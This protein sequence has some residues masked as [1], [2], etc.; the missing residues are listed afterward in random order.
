AYDSLTGKS[1][2]E[3][4]RDGLAHQR[5]QGAGQARTALG[6]AIS[7]WLLEESALPKTENEQSLFDG[8]DTTI[9][10]MAKLAGSTDISSDLTRISSR[11]EAAIGKFDALKPWVVASDLAAATEY[12]RALIEKVKSSSI[13]AANKDQLLFMLGNKETELNDAMNKALGLAMEVLVD[14]ERA[15]E[16]PTPFFQSRETFNVAIPGQQFSLTMSVVNRS[17]VK[18]D[19]AE[20]L[21]FPRGGWD[22]KSKSPV[23]GLPV[24][25]S[26]L[27]AQFDLKVHDNAEY[28]RPHWSRD[29]ELRDH[30]YQINKP[31]YLHLPFPPPDVIGVFNYVFEGVRFTLT[32]PAQTVYIDRPWGEQRRLLTVAPAMNVAISPRV[33]VIPIASSQA[34]FDVNVSVSNNV[35]GNATGKVRLKLPQGWAASP[36]ESSFSF[37]HEGE[38]GNF[39]FKVSVPQ[40]A[41]GAD[42]KVHAVAEYNGKEYVEGYQVIGR[43]DNEPRH[44]YRPA[45]M[46]VRGVEV[47]AAPNL[48]V[49][50]V[51]GVGDESPKALEQ[52]GAKV[53]ALG[54]NDLAKGNLDVFDA[55]I[56]GIRATA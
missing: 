4:A 53:V 1:Y 17:P 12:T 56:I 32:R 49:G 37:T 2:R 46:D 3:I 29:N 21:I 5:S 23:G 43:R 7:S 48:T 38:V 26:I 55:V 39:N 20:T 51:M 34:S 52:I 27:R 50:Y 47:K 31:E 13:E 54:E 16:G 24:N 6:S 25:N 30:V 18:L 42:Y 44:L 40:V 8:I 11:V 22:I 36:A 19:K 35:K 14:P 15:P 33:G 45:T 41:L 9:A 28:T 10:G